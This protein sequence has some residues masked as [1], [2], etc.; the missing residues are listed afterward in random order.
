MILSVNHLSEK[1]EETAK[2][3]E[4]TGKRNF[5]LNYKPL[6]AEDTL[7]RALLTMRENLKTNEDEIT[8]ANRL[9]AFVSDINKT[10]VHATDQ[11]TL[12]N[13]TCRIA[14]TI[15]KFEL[16]C[17]DI[18]DEPNKRL[19]LQ[20]QNNAAL[21]EVELFNNVEYSENGTMADVLRTGKPYVINDYVKESEE[22]FWKQYA[23]S[24]EFRSAII[25]PLKKS[26][27]TQCLLSLFSQKINVFD[28]EELKLLEETAANISFALDVFEND[29]HRKQMEEDVVH[30][31]L[32]L[33][34]AQAIAHFGS[35]EMDFSNG[36]VIWSEEALRIYGIPT[37]DNEQ[38]FESWVSFIH[39]EDRDY[40]LKVTGAG[41][42]TLS[43]SAFHHRIV[44]KD[45]TVR[46]IYSQAQFVFN[47]EG[48]P[49]GLQGVAHDETETKEAAVALVQSQAN[50]RLIVDLIPQPIF[51][52]DLDGKFIFTNENFASL[53]GSTPEEMIH[54][55][56]L[57][58]NSINSE[59]ENY[60]LKQDK[61]VFRSGKNKMIPEY[62]FTDHT[63]TVHFFNEVK[64]PYIVAGTNEK[65]VL[66]IITDISEQ[67]QVE[68]ERTKMIT[69]IM[70]RNKDLEQFS[71]IVS[72]N[73]RAPLANISGLAE[74]MQI[75]G[76]DKQ[77][78]KKLVSQLA[79]SVKKLDNVIMDLNYILQV[80]ETDS[81]KKE[82]VIFS[83]LLNDIKISIDN[84]IRNEGVCII[85]DFSAIDEMVTFK[86]YL[87]SIFLNLITNSIK[88]RQ[89]E[90]QPVI[91]ITSTKLNNK[92]Q[93]FFKDN[94]MG[95]D[96]EKRGDQVFGL[97][98]RFHS[99]VEG[100]GMGLY[101]VKTQ[102]EA[103]DGKI[104]VSSEVNK[105]TAF[106]IEFELK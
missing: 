43:S 64:V 6:S 23:F 102:V 28:D 1:L 68:A 38:T 32:R 45:G 48:A 46:Y 18:L 42:K 67:K 98:K 33:K 41:Q 91:E 55:S 99:H 78:E 73:L 35:W 37:E 96:L 84:V 87:Y 49:T 75:I 101:M 56:A 25:L 54:K 16:A 95:M 26:G 74:V 50:L 71:Y 60:Y 100:K 94:G 3:A 92:I 2:F 15:G 11:Q 85:G 61:E 89:P 13:E 4:E 90:I 19:C 30:S 7:G 105:G 86:A 103:L 59:A 93:I 57:E 5:A 53:Y 40:V 106:R 17:I 27:K 29:R 34:Q 79:G 76:F 24:K 82:T 63:G 44:R 14:V 83:E 22:S 77:D 69:D 62:Q 8:N 88:Y 21:A 12:F 58:A 31:E 72:H 20:S 70:Q 9:Y 104:T 52:K 66:G 97:Y 80:K 65:A 39:P 51:A 10:I 47:K 81:K 36:I